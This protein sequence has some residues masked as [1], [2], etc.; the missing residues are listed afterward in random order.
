MILVNAIGAGLIGLIVWWFWLYKPSD[1]SVGDDT[2][3]IEVDKGV[4]QPAHLAVA[5]NTPLTLCFIRR[6]ESPCAETVVF[7]AL[8]ISVALGLEAPTRIELPPLPAGTYAFHCQMQMY[9]GTLT[10][11]EKES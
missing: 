4:Y 1:V 9:K 7:P 2:L 10:V 11:K 8:D 5:A 3:L 6:D